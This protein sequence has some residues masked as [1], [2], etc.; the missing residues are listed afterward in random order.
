MFLRAGDITIATFD[1]IAAAEDLSEQLNCFLKEVIPNSELIDIK[2][3]TGGTGSNSSLVMFKLAEQDFQSYANALEPEA[4]DIQEDTLPEFELKP[5][6]SNNGERKV[7]PTEEGDSSAFPPDDYVKQFINHDIRFVQKGNGTH[8][9]I[10]KDSN[11]KLGYQFWSTTETWRGADNVR[12]EGIYHL[13][14]QIAED[15]AN[16]RW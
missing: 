16:G 9:H 1:E 7:I 14:E 12:N 10:L 5:F 2:F 8:F 4:K 15:K 11:G 6:E 3:A 13:L